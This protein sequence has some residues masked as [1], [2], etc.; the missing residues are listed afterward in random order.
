[1][2]TSSSFEKKKHTHTHTPPNKI[3]KREVPKQIGKHMVPFLS[4]HSNTDLEAIHMA[5]I[6]DPRA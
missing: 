6:P 3:R 4:S 2:H 5:K 1:M